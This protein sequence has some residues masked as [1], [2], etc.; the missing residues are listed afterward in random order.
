M[1]KEKPSD[2]F[3]KGLYVSFHKRVNGPE[4]IKIEGLKEVLKE[5]EEEGWK[6][7]NVEDI[8]LNDRLRYIRTE[9]NKQ[10]FVAGGIVRKINNENSSITYLS[11][12]PQGVYKKDLVRVWIKEA[13]NP[14]KIKEPVK[15]IINFKIPKNPDA[16]YKVHIG[17]DL[18]FSTN[19]KT[20]Y[21]KFLETNKYKRALNGDKY[22]LV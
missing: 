22:V 14:I 5:M 9:G 20:V 15:K 18:I 1:E 13:I 16:K 12:K 11:G 4:G 10:K 6:E 3:K 2:L 7:V 8:K 17:D 21:T 19:D